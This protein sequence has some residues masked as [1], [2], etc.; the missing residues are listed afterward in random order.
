[1]VVELHLNSRNEDLLN[2]EADIAVR[3][4]RP[5]QAAIVAKC[6]GIVPLGLFAARTF[7]EEHGSPGSIEQ[8]S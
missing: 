5:T 2:Q 7:L 8:L 1:L 6:V 3:M 4:V